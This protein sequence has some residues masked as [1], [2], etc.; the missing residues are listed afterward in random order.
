MP[1]Y[2]KTATISNAAYTAVGSPSFTIPFKAK[3]VLVIVMHASLTAKY[4]FD[5]SADPAS[6][7][8][9][10]TA[11][12]GTGSSSIR[13]DSAPSK[14]GDNTLI[15]MKAASSVDVQVIAEG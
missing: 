11:I 9:E 5:F 15:W 7:N 10:V 12:G 14:D 13:F 8:Q 6:A 3:S 2:M 1:Q 4:M